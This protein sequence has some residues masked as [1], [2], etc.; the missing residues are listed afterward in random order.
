[1]KEDPSGSLRDF[2]IRKFSVSYDPYNEESDFSHLRY[3]DEV[4]LR[5]SLV[6]NVQKQAISDLV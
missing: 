2:G 3:E 4:K 1:M 6:L 5:A